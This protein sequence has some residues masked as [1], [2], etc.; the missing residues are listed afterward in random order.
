MFSGGGVFN[1]NSP[2]GSTGISVEGLGVHL[3]STISVVRLD[4]EKEPTGFLTRKS[5]ISWYTQG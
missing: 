5:G 3:V 1:S 4:V 2:V